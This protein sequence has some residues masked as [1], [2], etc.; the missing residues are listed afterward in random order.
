MGGWW[1]HSLY[2]QG[3]LVEL[4]SWVFWVIFS[5]TLHELAH[6]WA[7]IWQG[8]QT[9]RRLGRMTANPLVHM[10]KWSLLVFAIMGIAW[11]VMPVDPSRFRW[12]RRGR[13]VVSGAGPAMNVALTFA[14]LALLVVWLAVGPEGS[15]V[16]SNLA[17][18]LF[19]GGKL[20]IVLAVF[21][22]LPVPPLDGSS[23]LA[24]LS[25]RYYQFSQRPQAQ[26]VGMFLVMIV[27][28]TGCG[29]FVFRAA[30][31]ASAGT[32]DLAGAILGSPR[33]LDVVY[34]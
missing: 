1:V 20:N 6:G 3:L 17:I 11:G 5:I 9:P 13:V 8:D 25:L 26:M 22:L 10:G 29:G 34:P 4:I 12:G 19:T 31:I 18:F 15:P 27:L 28:V 16:Y 33:V 32:V 30:E 2:Q 21:N 14:A 7:A 23:I 24:G